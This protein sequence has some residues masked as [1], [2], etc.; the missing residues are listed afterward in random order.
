[1]SLVQDT[2]TNL[3]AGRVCTHPVLPHFHL[4]FTL[5]NLSAHPCANDGGMQRP[6]L[7]IYPVPGG[8]SSRKYDCIASHPV[9][10]LPFEPS[11]AAPSALL[12]LI[13]RIK[14]AV[15]A[16]LMNLLDCHWLAKQ[17]LGQSP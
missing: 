3:L 17:L 8:I 16:L 9:A 12:L 7:P 2:Q 1:M 4:L 10:L 5:Q 11:S 14:L 13:G 15:P 6:C